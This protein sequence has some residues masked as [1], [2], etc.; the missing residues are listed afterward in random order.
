MFSSSIKNIIE[1]SKFI[2]LF[3]IDTN[4]C[5]NC[6]NISFNDFSGHDILIGTF[7]P[8]GGHNEELHLQPT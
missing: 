4:I 7:L 6:L 1:M 8:S 2:Y 5:V 3:L